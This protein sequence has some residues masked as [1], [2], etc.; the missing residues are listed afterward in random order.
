MAVRVEL[1]GQKGLKAMDE[2]WDQEMV[3]MAETAVMAAAA[4]TAAVAQAATV[5]V[6]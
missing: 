3:V 6:F 2:A 4:A 1:E 5:S